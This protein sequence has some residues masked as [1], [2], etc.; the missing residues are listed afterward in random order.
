MLFLFSDFPVLS[1]ELNVRYSCLNQESNLAFTPRP[2]SPSMAALLSGISLS[3]QPYYSKQSAS[4]PLVFDI[5]MRQTSSETKRLRS[6]LPGCVLVGG[7]PFVRPCTIA[8]VGTELDD[9][10]RFSE[11]QS[12]GAVGRLISLLYI[13]HIRHTARP[14]SPTFGIRHYRRPAC[15]VTSFQRGD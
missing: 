12:C 10:I 3:D 11:L 2:F 14:R 8:R 5:S 13:L 9:I 6:L 4:V 15:A 1:I 7:S